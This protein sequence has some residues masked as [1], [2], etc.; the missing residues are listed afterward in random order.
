VGNGSCV[1]EG[2]G[3]EVLVPADVDAELSALIVAVVKAVLVGVEPS[4]SSARVLIRAVLIRVARVVRMCAVLI[5][6]TL[7][8]VGETMTCDGGHVADLTAALSGVPAV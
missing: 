1:G 2:A 8:R 4:A 5:H 7:I 6:S 3:T